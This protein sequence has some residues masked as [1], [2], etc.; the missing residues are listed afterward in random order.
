MA[1]LAAGDKL[2]ASR[3]NNIIDTGWT[4]HT[5]IWT[6]ST[7]NPAIGN[8]TLAGRYRRPTDSD[9]LIY[10]VRMVAGSTTT[11]GSG[12][13]IFSLPFDASANS[14]LFSVGSVYLSDFGTISRVGVSRFFSA[15]QLI[16]DSDQGVVASGVPFA[17]ANGDEARIQTIYEPV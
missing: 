8:G 12:F 11:F 17:W 4:S 3:A 7:T 14:V 9:W 6:A 13:W 15:T 16:I 5:P 10:E 1:L 2:T